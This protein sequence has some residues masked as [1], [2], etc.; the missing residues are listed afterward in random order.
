MPQEGRGA[1]KPIT[2]PS[3]NGGSELFRIPLNDD[4]RE[5]VQPGD[6]EVLAFDGSITDFALT[7]NSQ[8]VFQGMVG[9][10]L[11]ETD[12][13]PALN[14]DIENPFDDEERSFDPP[15]FPRRNREVMLLRAA[16]QGF[17]E[18]ARS[19]PT[20]NHRRDASK[21][22]WPVCDDRILPDPVTCQPL[23]LF[24]NGFPIKHLQLSGR[25]IRD[26]WAGQICPRT[27]AQ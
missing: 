9:F 20:G 14:F 4:G 19:D 10:A 6:A 3:F 16:S 18:L 22:I 5:Q 13:C 12:I 2:P 21:D 1:V 25:E 7:P 24:G 8:G 26:A 11:V 17:Q 23:Q 15:D 27:E